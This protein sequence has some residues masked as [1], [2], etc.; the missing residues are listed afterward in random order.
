MRSC[1]ASN[2][3]S[4]PPRGSRVPGAGTA[5]EAYRMARM[6]EQLTQAL[7]QESLSA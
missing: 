2:A 1:P 6:A 7:Y 3:S 5:D 4:P